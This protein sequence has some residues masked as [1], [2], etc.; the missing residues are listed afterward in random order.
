[1]LEIFQDMIMAR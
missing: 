1:M